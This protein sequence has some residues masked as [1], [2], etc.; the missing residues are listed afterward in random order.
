MRNLIPTALLALALPLAEFGEL[1]GGGLAR[2]LWRIG[3]AG[4]AG[5]SRHDG[6][7][8]VFQRLRGAAG[9]IL[10]QPFCVAQPRNIGLRVACALRII[11]C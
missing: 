1:L 7:I 10:R 6:A 2:R 5:G 9:F 4:A 11:Q 8:I 3:T